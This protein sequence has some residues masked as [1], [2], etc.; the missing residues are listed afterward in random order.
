MADKKKVDLAITGGKLITMEDSNPIDE[1]GIA[2][3]GD[4]IVFVGTK[5]ELI[6]QFSPKKEI[7]ASGCVVMPGLVNGTRCGSDPTRPD[8]RQFQGSSGSGRQPSAMLPP[9]R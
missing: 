3:S 6:P 7:D 8:S 9:T 2:I 5:K 1:G 4:S